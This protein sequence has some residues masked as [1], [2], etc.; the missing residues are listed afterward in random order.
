LFIVEWVYC[1]VGVLFGD[2]KGSMGYSSER[3]SKREQLVFDPYTGRYTLRKE[4]GRCSG[5]AGKQIAGNTESCY[6]GMADLV[7]AGRQ[8]K[9]KG[10]ATFK[11]ATP[12][13]LWCRREDSNFHEDTP[14]RP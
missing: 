2:R 14:T 10:V 8:Q 9:T 7:W 1:I 12:Y 3:G 5:K 4:Q 11:I 6:T 13:L